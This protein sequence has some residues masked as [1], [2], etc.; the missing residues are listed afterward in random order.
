MKTTFLK[1]FLFILFAQNTYAQCFEIESILVDACGA[2]EGLNEMV[3]FKV[4]TTPLNTSTLNV[5][6]PNNS[7]QGLIQNATTASK[8]AT[9]NADVINAG[10]CGEL[11]EPIGGVLPANAT[12]IL[13][14]SFNFDTALNAFGAL[15]EDIY[16]IFQNN[17][18]TTAGHFANFGTGLRTLTISIGSCV[19][20]VTYDRALLVSPTGQNTAA[21]GATVLFDPA[22]NATYVNYG[23]L[24]P[25]Q[26]FLVDINNPSSS[27]CPGDVIA[28][29]GTAEGHQSVLW[30]APVGVFSN[31]GGLTTSYTIPA[32]ATGTITLTLT[33]VNSCGLEI[34]DTILL[35]ISANIIPDFIT[36]LTLCNGDAAPALNTTSPNGISGT[37][38]P[39]TIDNTASGNYT[40][41]PNPNQCALPV[42]L[43]ITVTN[44]IVPD[45]DTTL[46][47]CNGT[48]APALNISS[49]NG[50]T[51]MWSPS[52]ID[53]A[54][55]G[56]YTF[57]PDPNQC[58]SP[59]TLT[60]TVTNTIVP[61]F[62]TTLMLCNG[63][64]AP[65]LNT[66]SP[67]GI[68][69]MW[70]PSAINNTTGGSYT[71]TPDPDQ[72]GSAV[73]LVVTIT[74]ITVPDFATTLTLCI[75]EPAPALNTSSPNGI[76][77]TWS[78][79]TIDNTASGNYTFTPNP[80]QCA[81]PVTLTVTVTNTIV[82]DFDTTLTL[83]NGETAPAL[84]TTSPNGINGTWS[85]S[86]I[87]NTSSGNY[88]F[89]PAP[90]Q[91]SSPVT[92]AVTVTTTIVP[93]FNTVLTLCSGITA[94]TLNTISPNGITGT[95]SPST[96][97][98]STGGN[99]VFTPDPN[100][101]ASPVTLTVTVTDTIVP[102]FDT[103][104]TLCSNAT[105]PA[106][107]TISPNGITGTWNPSVIDNTTNGNYV[108]TPDPNQC[109]SSVTLTVNITD[110]SFT[111]NE[112]CEG[113]NFIIEAVLED[114][115]P[116]SNY[117][118]TLENSS[119]ILSEESFLN[120][121]E[122]LNS[123]N[124][125]ATFPITFFLKIYT[126]QGCE[127]T[128]SITIHN[129]FCGIPKGISPNN[130]GLN[131]SFDLAG[132]GVE[133]ISIF[134]R[135]GRKVYSKNNY[136]DEWYGQSDNGHELPDGTYYFLLNQSDGKQISGWVY[137]IR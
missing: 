135:Y 90:N 78:P 109:G 16:I 88:V 34:S 129:A 97:D 13:V 102:D 74:N 45:F 22:G 21:D 116:D 69:G 7:W 94:P 118:W 86:V 80:N 110:F 25:V 67:N 108:F 39:S 103:A 60:V 127:K 41:T 92:L 53:N 17:A 72:C 112:K 119:S 65:A 10:G 38:N 73:T 61:D 71:F 30:T 77:G 40:F 31:P 95:W 20:V 133:H 2:Q 68:T 122:L 111:F 130:D 1:F 131:D 42:T 4:G 12:V 93:D 83:C 126:D 66:T 57:T 81:S 5:S 98:N 115:L 37:W 121:T 33:A 51:G 29:S 89:T 50:I 11:I 104:L 9:L 47:L 58:A 91:C 32:D 55:T 75:G 8:V 18:A 70:S 62:D 113:R 54:T 87:N 137:L 56:N 120:V 117:E 24:A 64:A 125:T 23:C 100:Q 48:T 132:L 101:C 128:D 106:L 99:Y 63:E 49:P 79:S 124:F 84:N 46:T 44:T 76:T 82:P 35:T 28:L 27:V 43:T 114:S 6:W 123:S 15:A 59:V 96:I 36:T 26:P 134:N 85:P 3:R 105:V 52:A 14:T 19:D 136:I 107:N